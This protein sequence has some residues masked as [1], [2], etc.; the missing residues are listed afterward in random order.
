MV[1]CHCACVTCHAVMKSN[2]VML[3]EEF[4]SSCHFSYWLMYLRLIIIYFYCG[5]N[6]N[7]IL[8]WELNA[9]K[10]MFVG[11]GYLP[12]WF[13]K[14]HSILFYIDKDC[15]ERWSD[16]TVVAFS[17]LAGN[18]FCDKMSNKLLLHDMMLV[19]LKW[20]AVSIASSIQA[21]NIVS[22]LINFL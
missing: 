15:A 6:N 19:W 9:F 10:T 17:L 7:V 20:S 5:N 12:F 3:V 14:N 1:L 22:L 2:V 4:A 11:W 16:R 8:F 13:P 21:G 18:A